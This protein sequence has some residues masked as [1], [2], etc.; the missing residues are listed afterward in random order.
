MVSEDFI[1]FLLVA[2]A[3]SFQLNKIR[4]HENLVSAVTDTTYQRQK[5]DQGKLNE[6]VSDNSKSLS[7]QTWWRLRAPC[8]G[9]PPAPA[10]GQ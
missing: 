5:E 4:G 2:T 1:P 7:D 6:L 3:H 8:S 10:E 9:P